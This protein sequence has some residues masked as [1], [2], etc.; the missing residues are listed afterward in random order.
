MPFLPSFYQH[1]WPCT[2]TQLTPDSRAMFCP[3]LYK[4][5]WFLPSESPKAP[6]LSGFLAEQ[7]SLENDELS[8]F[9]NS[10]EFF[11]ACTAFQ[12]H[13]HWPS[14]YTFI[15]I[16]AVLPVWSTV[17]VFLLFH[18]VNCQERSAWLFFSGF[19]SE[20]WKH[21]FEAEKWTEVGMEEASI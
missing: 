19:T 17:L 1:E 15:C 18:L 8:C 4:K 16:D 5:Y 11:P 10:S 12:E 7:I 14:M 13:V 6:L 3:W 21:D 2:V 20:A 9:F